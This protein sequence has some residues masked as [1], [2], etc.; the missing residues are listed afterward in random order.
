MNEF[1][2]KL[3]ARFEKESHIKYDQLD[4]GYCFD[5]EH[6]IYTSDAIKI[7]NQLA[8]EHNNGFCEW[9]V[10]VSSLNSSERWIYYDKIGCTPNEK[11]CL[12]TFH[13]SEREQRNFLKYC[14]YCGKPIK[15]V[16]VV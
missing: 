5:A 4:N 9:T 11:D 7:V 8:E 10:V 6:F 15:F 3:I 1:I 2:E 13:F 12:S 14:P 16:G